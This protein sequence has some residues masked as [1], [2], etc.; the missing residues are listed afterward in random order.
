MEVYCVVPQVT[1]FSNYFSGD[2]YIGTRAEELKR[3]ADRITE[4]EQEVRKLKSQQ[5]SQ[6]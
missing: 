6:R 4:L 1:N 5:G 3:R 2:P